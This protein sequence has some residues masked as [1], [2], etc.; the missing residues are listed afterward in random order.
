MINKSDFTQIIVTCFVKKNK[1]K[2]KCKIVFS[3]DLNMSKY[4]KIDLISESVHY[5]YY[6]S[7]Q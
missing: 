5:A 2:I 7:S 3:S 4:S 6:L 1:K